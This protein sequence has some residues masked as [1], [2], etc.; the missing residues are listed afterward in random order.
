MFS[1]TSE[2]QPHFKHVEKATDDATYRNIRHAAF[3]IS[4]R[5][6]ASI[7]KSKRPSDP[8]S[9]PNTRGRGRKNIRGAIFTDSDR[10][11]AVIGPRYS[12]VGD[13]G[14]AHEFGRKR[15]G[16]SFEERSFMGKSLAE[17]TDRFAASWHGSIG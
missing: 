5:A 14:E 2:I 4:K 11:S 12:F 9:P 13:V 16:D 8:G 6:K 3:S 17:S 10:Y 15:K 1:M 7:K